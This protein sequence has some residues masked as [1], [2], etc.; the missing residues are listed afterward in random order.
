MTF[1]FEI[2]IFKELIQKYATWEKLQQFLESEEGGLFRI[3]DKDDK[4]LC[5]IRYEKGTTNMSLPHSKW[6]RSV[7]WDTVSNHPVCIAPCKTSSEEFPYSGLKTMQAAG[8]LCQENLEG[9]M[10][11]CFQKVDDTRLH[12][13]SR[14]KL[15]AAG[16]FYSDK[17]FCELFVEAYDD[18]YQTKGAI[19]FDSLVKPDQGKGELSVYYS[20][21]VQHMEHKIVKDNTENRVHIIQRG[22]VYSDGRISVEDMDLETIPIPSEPIVKPSYANIVA[23]NT[24]SLSEVQDWFKQILSEKPREFQGLVLKD[25]QGNRWRVRSEKYSAIRSLSGNSPSVR[26]R[27]SQLYTANL[28]HKYLEYYPEDSWSMSVCLAETNKI[29]KQLY[30]LYVQL[31]ILK[32]KK[33]EDIDKMFHPHL[34]SLHGMYLSQ[35]RPS[36]KVM[37]QQAV[38]LYLHKQPWQRLSFLIRK[39]VNLRDVVSL[40][41]NELDG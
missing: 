29:I 4:G 36:G 37:T 21:L 6:F 9:F 8:I 31:H 11:N 39:R 40:V 13:T 22:T 24:S 19:R 23:S 10:I 20:Y 41:R 32:A 5:L 15:N 34:Y 16:T 18:T 28:I 14:S 1:T 30:D 17:T 12:I 33:V 25:L 3:I 26:D 38:Q 35:L 7:V 27:F 2:T